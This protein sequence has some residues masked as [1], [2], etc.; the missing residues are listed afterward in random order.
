M[1]IIITSFA[2]GIILGVKPLKCLVKL[3]TTWRL[4]EREFSADFLYLER[5]ANRK[6]W[7]WNFGQSRIGE[8]GWF[9]KIRMSENL[10]KNNA[11]VGKDATILELSK[12]HLFKYI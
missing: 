8:G 5:P 1:P 10:V 9:L 4:P 2:N 3:N 12:S 7:F 6:G 11:N